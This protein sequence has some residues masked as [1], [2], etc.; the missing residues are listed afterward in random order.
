[1]Q[2]FSKLILPQHQ[3]QNCK[4]HQYTSGHAAP[5]ATTITTTA[6]TN[7]VEDMML[8]DDGHPVDSTFFNAFSSRSPIAIISPFLPPPPSSSPPPSPFS[9][10]PPLPL[11]T[12]CRVRLDILPDI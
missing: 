4:Q 9:P 1:M 6:T 8:L 3:Q 10:L 11:Q 7:S 5:E 12:C 2:K